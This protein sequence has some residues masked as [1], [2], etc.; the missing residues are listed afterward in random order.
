MR[1]AF[2]NHWPPNTGVG[3]YV[4]SLFS[5]LQFYENIEADMFCVGFD[6]KRTRNLGKKVSERIYFLSQPRNRYLASMFKH[7][8]APH[9]IPKLYDLYHVSDEMIARFTKID[10][11]TIITNHGPLTLT[12]SEDAFAFGVGRLG[13]TYFLR[14][15]FLQNTYKNI[16]HASKIIC[17]SEF[18]KKNLL[19]TLP[20]DPKKVKVIYYGLDHESFKLRDKNE[21]RKEL[22]LPLN[23][24]IILNVGNESHS[25]NI[26]TLVEAFYRIKKRINEVML[27]K[28][29]DQLE[30]TEFLVKNLGLCNFLHFKRVSHRHVA[31]F[32]NAADLFVFPSFY[33]GFGFP[34]MEAMA[35]G[36]PVIA[37]NRTAIPEIAGDAAILVNPF[38]MESLCVEMETCLKDE[39]L[40]DELVRKG[41][42]RAS[43]FTWEKCARETL[44]TYHELLD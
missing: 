23:K 12:A 35:S 3:T 18:S 15:T 25:K 36:C 34:V 21:C 20:L 24:K 27:V 5:H 44:Q 42:K 33:E 14:N 11:P 6:P 26:P 38:D 13:P 22:G 9:S 32:Y 7:F 30:S 40:R 39:N 29:G 8:L 41:I 31:H 43:I 17:I 19:A 1:I 4:F 28:V 2:I 10:N 37:G 16:E